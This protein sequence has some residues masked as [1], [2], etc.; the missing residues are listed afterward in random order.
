MD[1]TTL[2]LV[3]GIAAIPPTLAI[4]LAYYR[5]TKA[6]EEN[7]RKQEKIGQNVDT[8]MGNVDGKVDALIRAARAEGRLEANE[9]RDRA[10]GLLR[11]RNKEL[12]QARQEGR[13]EKKEP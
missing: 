12:E 9:E 7:S 3:A 1:R 13:Q 11:E 4:W 10:N 8:V 5:F 2:L 6:Q